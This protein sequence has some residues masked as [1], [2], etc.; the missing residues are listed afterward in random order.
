VLPIPIYDTLWILLVAYV[1]LHLPYGMRFAASGLAQIHRELEEAAEASGAGMLSMFRRV[2]LP[3]L[4][5]VLIASFLYVF[6]LTVR[7]FAASVF[8]VGPSTGVL[9]TLS[10]TLWQDGGSIGAI[11]ALG[12]LEIA[13]LAIIAWL[14]RRFERAVAAR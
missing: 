10:L 1:T 7:E 12:S 2:L 11:S 3:L 5:P 9:A 4:A 14:M 6:M 8:L 13:A